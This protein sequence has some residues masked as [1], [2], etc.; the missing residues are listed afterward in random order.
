MAT[1]LLRGKTVFMVVS[2]ASPLVPQRSIV[3]LPHA[4]FIEFMHRIQDKLCLQ[5]PEQIVFVNAWHADGFARIGQLHISL[6][7]GL[8]PLLSYQ[9]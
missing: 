8:R 3:L 9:K 7:E 4:R 5:S 2:A 1:C 6:G